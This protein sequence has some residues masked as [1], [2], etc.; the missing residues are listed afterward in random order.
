MILKD[1]IIRYKIIMCFLIFKGMN[2]REIYTGDR[3]EDIKIKKEMGK[4]RKDVG[5]IYKDV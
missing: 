2:G 3:Y 4:I 5:E 1:V